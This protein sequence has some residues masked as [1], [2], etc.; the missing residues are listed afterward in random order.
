MRGLVLIAMMSVLMMVAPAGAQGPNTW[1]KRAPF[2]E[3][4]EELV[5]TST[6]GKF[7][8]FGGLR[9]ADRSMESVGPD[10]LETR[11]GC[12]RGGER[13]DLCDRRGGRPSWIE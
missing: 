11:V 8:V 4:S 10:A 9:P 3:P 12:C 5:G 7:Y 1:I 13:L 6:N 2:P